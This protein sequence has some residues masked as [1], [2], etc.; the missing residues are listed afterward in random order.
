MYLLLCP[1]RA[2][3]PHSSQSNLQ[4][5]APHAALCCTLKAC[6]I[7][8]VVLE[9]R[10]GFACCIACTIAAAVHLALMLTTIDGHAVCLAGRTQDR[11]IG[12]RQVV[13]EVT[14]DG[15]VERAI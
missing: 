9:A 1:H 8:H 15:G 11:D 6:E 4:I 13:V 5:V 10:L 14:R 7:Q 12:E 2:H 3:L